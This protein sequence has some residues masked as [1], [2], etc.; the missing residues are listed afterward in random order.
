MNE[1][2]MAYHAGVANEPLSQ[3]LDKM[4]SHSQ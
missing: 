1:I 3:A 4:R 2:E